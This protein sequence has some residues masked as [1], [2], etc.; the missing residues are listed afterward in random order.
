MFMYFGPKVGATFSLEAMGFG[1]P[2]RLTV[3]PMMITIRPVSEATPWGALACGPQWLGKAL[4]HRHDWHARLL[5]FSQKPSVWPRSLKISIAS[6]TSPHIPNIS[7][8]PYTWIGNY[9]GL[10]AT[11]VFWLGSSMLGD[12]SHEVNSRTSTDRS[13]DS[14]SRR[15]TGFITSRSSPLRRGSFPSET[16]KASYLDMLAASSV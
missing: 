10:T 7:I 11:Q 4:V 14:V 3:A 8:A 9:L 1:L 13:M 6:Y 12:R 2:R 5:A 15:R 16:P